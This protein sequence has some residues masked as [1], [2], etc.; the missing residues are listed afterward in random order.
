[1]IWTQSLMNSSM[2][3]NISRVSVVE[4]I[5]FQQSGPN[6]S[7]RYFIL[8]LAEC[9]VMPKL[10][11]RKQTEGAQFS[12]LLNVVPSSRNLF[13]GVKIFSV[14]IEST[15]QNVFANEHA[16]KIGVPTYVAKIVVP[17]KI[18]PRYVKNAYEV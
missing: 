18:H 4:F 5:A 6:L 12:T 1:M 14:G 17:I 8:C 3:A 15:L 16:Q 10:L 2:K 11:I 7:D 13:P 9:A